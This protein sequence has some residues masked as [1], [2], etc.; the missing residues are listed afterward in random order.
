MPWAAPPYPPG[1]QPPGIGY[2]LLIGGIT[3]CFIG[4]VLYAVARALPAKKVDGAKGKEDSGTDR[5][6]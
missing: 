5:Q 1:F 6:S 4:I 2:L 3:L